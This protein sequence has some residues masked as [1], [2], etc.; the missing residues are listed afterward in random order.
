MVEMSG[1]VELDD[2]EVLQLIERSKAANTVRSD[3]SLVSCSL[4]IIWYKICNED[5]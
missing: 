1:V 3:L 5:I 2:K 4:I